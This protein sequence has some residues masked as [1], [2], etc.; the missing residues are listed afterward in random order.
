MNK[1]DLAKETEREFL[2]RLASDLPFMSHCPV[3]FLSAKTGRGVSRVLAAVSHVARAAR[4]TLPTGPLNRCLQEACSSNAAP[5][6]ADRPLKLHYAVQ[7]GANPIRVRLFVNDPRR[8]PASFGQF[9]A[10]TLR[11]A[12]DLAGVGVLLQFRA[13]ERRNPD[14]TP[15]AA[16]APSN[17]RAARAAKKAAGK[18]R[19]RRRAMPRG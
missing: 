14:G 17:L 7:T 16:P 4:Q 6:R 11:K 19:T 3:V 18:S 12:F 1:W 8:M 9:L 13:R 10:N 15:K 2:E 5:S